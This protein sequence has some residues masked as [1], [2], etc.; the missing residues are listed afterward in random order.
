[1]FAVDVCSATSVALGSPAPF[2]V[3]AAWCVEASWNR[4]ASNRIIYAIY[5]LHIYYFTYYSVLLCL[6]SLPL[7]SQ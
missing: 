4:M 3:E 5:L 7:Y 6:D 1:M 2:V